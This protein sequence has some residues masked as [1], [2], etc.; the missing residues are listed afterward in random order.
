MDSIVQS[1]SAAIASGSVA[2]ALVG[3]LTQRRSA[4][5]QNEIKLRFD[6]LAA[7]STSHRVWS[8][9]A[10][11]ELLGPVNM[12]LD[13][14][15]RAFR[16]WTTR[17]LFLEAK[18]IREGNQCI[19]DLLLAKGHLIPPDLLED[20]GK[21]IEHY[22]RWLEEFDKVRGDR[23]PKLD[24]SF[25]FVGVGPNAVPFPRES[26]DRFQQRFRDVWHEA[27]GER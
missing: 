22:D 1:V 26:A 14:T 19:R 10:L 2:A 21:L 12:Q 9:Q 13:R 3:V 7:R 27:Y 16:R 17:S 6:D 18:V 25:V 24:E 11:A 5:I 4:S 23:N 20:A 15:E 8:Q